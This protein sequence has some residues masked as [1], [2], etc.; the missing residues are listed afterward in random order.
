MFRRDLFESIQ[1]SLGVTF[2][3]DAACNDEGTNALCARYASPGRSFLASNV[4]GEC[5][6]IN[7]PYSHIRDW[8]QHYMRCKAS[9]PEHTSAV[10]CVPAWPQVHRLMQKAKYS[11]VARYPA[12]TPLFSKPGPDGQRIPMAGTPWAVDLW[13]DKPCDEGIVRGLGPDSSIQVKLCPLLYEVTVAG[14]KCTA[15]A[16][17][18]AKCAEVADG[19]ISLA[20]AQQAGLRLEAPPLLQVQVANSGRSQVVGCVTVNVR[21]DCGFRDDAKLL[22][23]RDNI[24]GTDVVLA[25]EWM[26][27]RNAHMDVQR[28]AMTV[29]KGS[30]WHTLYARDSPARTDART[31][32]L[33][34]TLEA[35]PFAP[36][37]AKKA[38]RRL[39][40]GA[41]AYITLVQ[42]QPLALSEEEEKPDT[43]N[44]QAVSDLVPDS[45]L[46]ALLA[47]FE[48]VFQEPKE[49]PD[50]GDIG[51]TI[52]LKKG[53]TPP[54]KRSYRLTPKERDEVKREV[55]D[56]LA[57]GM[58]QPSTS[59]YGAPVIFVEK[60]DGS[61]RM[62]LDYRALNKITRK[63]R[64]PMPN[65]T[66]LFDQ[67]A[68]AKVFSSLDLQQGYNQIRI[69]PDD[70]PKTGFIAPGMGQFE[71]KVLCFG[72]TNAPATFQSVMN[73]M[74]GP[75]IGKF[76]LVYL[77][78]ILVFSK[79]AEEHKEHLRTVLE[80]LRKNQFK[81]KRSKCDF[82]RPELHFLGHIV[83]REGLKVDDRKIRV[84]REWEVPQDLHKL[85]A[86]LG[87]ANYFRRFIQGYSSLVAPL[88][89]L[90]GG[91]KPWKWTDACQAAFEGVKVALTQA[92]VL[93]LPEM[94]KPFTVWSDA[95]VHGTGAVLLQEERPVAYTSAKFSPAEYNYTTT[96]QE[97]LG[98]VRALEM[99]MY[100]RGGRKRDTSH[101]PSATCISTRA[102][103]R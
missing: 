53:A 71:Y 55:T 63:R 1:S 99:E 13:Y 72:L 101:R 31:K 18:G 59:P 54:A 8:Q 83:S 4:A 68:G 47:E 48:D 17:T 64:Y 78:D 38:A 52:P 25:L 39:S 56:L 2:T 91:K 46:Q 10:F 77:D 50:R 12:G 88:T 9:D 5:V 40:L 6:W 26:H 85:R 79:N 30:R 86:F 57:K 3:Y 94:D 27:K 51:H 15:L 81:A 76:V 33:L 34:H 92:P 45:E 29:R 98:T 20:K 19:Y 21:F 61:L 62:V 66:E 11:L 44:V 23:L 32:A 16:D 102:T 100:P 82:N 65:I 84:I 37:T 97:C 22:V 75:H 60:A 74:F 43:P 49:P 42:P 73:N 90:T 80:I 7:P 36:L 69:H 35:E 93:K 28:A 103:A 89:A 96:D 87:L 95:S 67:L 24:P 41:R 14:T 58:I 70:V